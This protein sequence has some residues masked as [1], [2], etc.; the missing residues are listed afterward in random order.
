MV[1]QGR[2]ETHACQLAPCLEPHR[3]ACGAT[4]GASSRARVA[5]MQAITSGGQ[6]LQCGNGTGRESSCGQ[7]TCL[8]TQ[9]PPRHAAIH[10]TIPSHG[11]VHLPCIRW[12]STAGHWGT[13]RHSAGSC[14]W[15]SAPVRGGMPMAA[16]GHN[17][18]HA[19]ERTAQDTLPAAPTSCLPTHPCRP[20]S[21]WAQLPTP[22]LAHAHGQ[23]S[24]NNNHTGSTCLAAVG[25]ALLATGARHATVQ[26]VVIGVQRLSGVGCA[27]QLGVITAGTHQSGQHCTRSLQRPPPAFP[28]T[29][30]PP[31]LAGFGWVGSNTKQGALAHAH[32]QGQASTNNNHTG[33][34]CLA[35]VGAALLATGARHATVQAVVIGVQRLS[36]VGCAW[37]LGV[38]TA[39][40]HQ[41]RQH[42]TPSRSAHLPPL[43]P[44]AQ[45]LLTTQPVGGQQCWPMG[46]ASPH[47]RQ[48][49][50]VP[51]MVDC[52]AAS[53]A[54]PGLRR[55]S[56]SKRLCSC[57]K[58]SVPGNPLSQT[59]VL[60]TRLAAGAGILA[61]AIRV[62]HGQHHIV[63]GC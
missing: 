35:A 7:P 37:Q 40:T 18:R 19:P 52:K 45:H 56:K 23:A 8:Y 29:A 17:C 63:F 3:A 5:A 38:I 25:A 20:S 14:H 50:S 57:S 30:A 31:A 32:G 61:H 27:W 60:L 59:S 36:G 13:T 43:P 53:D 22:T 28:P 47:A 10:R 34:T 4:A 58:S 16:R 44:T 1:L 62:L 42:C 39:G 6:I 24:T 49:W 41:S 12:G 15:C 54:T 55:I 21:G 51:A 11:Q 46:Q 9:P 33:S 48:F 26:A 2:L